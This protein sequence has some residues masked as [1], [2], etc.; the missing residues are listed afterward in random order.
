MFIN[1]PCQINVEMYRSMYTSCTTPR[2]ISRDQTRDTLDTADVS[3]VVSCLPKKYTESTWCWLKAEKNAKFSV[4]FVMAAADT[5]SKWKKSE[6]TFSR[7]H[8]IDTYHFLLRKIMQASNVTNFF[9]WVNE[10]RKFHKWNHTTYLLFNSKLKQHKY[11]LSFYFVTF[12]VVCVCESVCVWHSFFSL[13]EWVFSTVRQFI[14]RF[15]LSFSAAHNNSF[16]EFVCMLNRVFASRS[17]AERGTGR[18]GEK[19]KMEIEIGIFIRYK[20]N[21]PQDRR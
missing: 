21:G 9:F 17:P 4:N 10:A 7:S 13:S 18:E 20:S 8:Q 15:M 3:G 16:H 12:G 6:R 1:F 14:L 19:M 2:W 11:H 5:S